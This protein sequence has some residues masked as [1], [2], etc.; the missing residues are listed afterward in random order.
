MGIKN[1]NEKIAL[2]TTCT[3]HYIE[4]TIVSFK[5]FEL[6]NENIF[7]YYII[8]NSFTNE[9]IN[10]INQ[11]GINYIN[12]DLY[13][14]YK[15]ENG[16]P[17]PSECFWIFKC[18]NIFNEMGYKYSLGIDTDIFCNKKLNLSWLNTINTIAGAPKSLDLITAKTFL[19]KLDNIDKINKLYNIKHENNIP[20]MGAGILFF[21][22]ENYVKNKIFE[23]SILLFN[24]SKNND[25]PRKGDDSLLSLIM[26]LTSNN[27]Y[28][29]I[30]YNWNNY[31]Y[32][33]NNNTLPVSESI[34]IH[35]INIKPWSDKPIPDKYSQHKYVTKVWLKTK[36]TVKY[37]TLNDLTKKYKIYWFRGKKYNFGDEIT[38]WLIKKMYNIE[39][40]EPYDF[41][42]QN[43]SDTVLLGVGSIMRLSNKNTE[44]WGSGIRNI[45]QSDFKKSKKYH[46]VR[47]PFTRRQLI[48]LGFDCPETYGDPALLLPNYYNPKIEKKYKLGIIPHIIDYDNVFKKYS[49]LNNVK[50]IDFKTNNIESVVKQ[51]L[52][53]ENIISSS[54]HG[55]IVSVAYDIPCRWFK[56]SNK[57]KGDDIKFYDF[58]A[59]IDY[60][61]YIT[62]DFENKKS[63]I[64]IYNPIKIDN[65]DLVKILNNVFK[66]TKKDLKIDN[67]INSIPLNNGNIITNTSNIINK[68][69]SSED[70][71][72][73][74][75]AVIENPIPKQSP[76]PTQAIITSPIVTEKPKIQKEDNPTPNEKPKGI[77]K[78]NSDIFMGKS[79]KKKLRFGKK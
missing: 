75:K 69:K 46:L 32:F 50:I 22:N 28:K 1:I 30:D 27:L 57:I 6:K 59:S 38:P 48:N 42:K 21:N 31:H 29:F 74:N 3:Y 34:I 14:E 33:S 12:E 60:D 37:T 49:E 23:L 24:E 64:D 79:Y 44:V 53:C 55:L 2:F 56:Y 25:I 41:K 5:S 18:P 8:G 45:D 9:Q 35:S 15:I 72:N 66:Y 52:E 16:W 17:Y 65:F 43:D 11:N 70:T 62:F 77:H 73:G 61:V 47:G 67:I 71:S 7:D 10:L 4:H 19:S 20:A 40:N 68:K 54:L 58:F 26:Y 13:S 63:T 39:L 78:V 36:N 76:K 51:I